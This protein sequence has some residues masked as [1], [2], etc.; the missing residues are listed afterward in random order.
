MLLCARD[1]RFFERSL[2]LIHGLI[3]ARGPR[4]SGEDR[5]A[6]FVVLKDLHRAGE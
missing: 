5:G 1:A 6:V 3:E 4:S 2:V